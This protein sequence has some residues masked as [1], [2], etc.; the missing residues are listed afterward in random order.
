MLDGELLETLQA[1]WERRK[2]VQLPGYSPTLLSH[3]VFHRNGKRIGGKSG[4][5]RDVWHN[6][7]IAAGLGQMIEIE[8][9]G[10]KKKYYQ[11]K[12]FHDFRRTGC[13]DM[14]RAGIP[15]RV[16]MK[17]SGHKT[18]SVFDRYNIVSQ[19]DLKEAARKR[20]EH[21]QTQSRKSNVVSMKGGG[22][23]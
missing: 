11:G 14:I 20:S 2:V 23:T 18:R 13:R 3:F 4:D 17:I 19:N 15:E 21:A 6:A 8:S 10:K 5:I 9:D 16:A 22:N 1:Q 12:L 7:C